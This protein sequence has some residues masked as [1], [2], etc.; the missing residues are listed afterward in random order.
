MDTRALLVAMCGGALLL[1]AACDASDKEAGRALVA[2][3]EL[4]NEGRVIAALDALQEVA[5]RYPQTKAAVGAL[6]LAKPLAAQRL[7]AEEACSAYALDVGDYPTQVADF[8]KR[9]VGVVT[10]VWRGPYATAS[11]LGIFGDWAGK[12][13]CGLFPDRWPANDRPSV[14]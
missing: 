8:Y 14:P 3:Q 10:G 1:L 6:R 9:P 5:K 12:T 13:R 4:Q 7:F 11:Q 2:A